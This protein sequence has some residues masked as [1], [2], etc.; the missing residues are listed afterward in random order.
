M[1]DCQRLSA[2]WEAIHFA[3][4]H[5]GAD[6]FL[7]EVGFEFRDGAND[8][9]KQPAHR[10]VRGDVFPARDELNPKAVKLIDDAQEVL[11]RTRYPVKGGNDAHA[12]LPLS[13]ISQHGVQARA[14]S[15]AAGDTDVGVLTSNLKA[16]LLGE[17]AE[18]VKLI[19]DAL[20][21]GA[22]PGVDRTFLHWRCSFTLSSRVLDGA[23]IGRTSLISSMA[24]I[25][26][27]M[28]ITHNAY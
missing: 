7:D 26:N 27:V 1:A 17:N 28:S 12:E 3:P 16:P 25:S 22:Y 20:V 14:T 13:G 19:V 2:T 18:V 5:P 8:G 4:T 15:L 6:A 10:A 24:A 21:G 23:M 9:Q 11:G